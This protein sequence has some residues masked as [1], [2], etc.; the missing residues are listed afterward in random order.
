MSNIVLIRID[1]RLI[2]GQVM[3]GWAKVTLANRIIIIDDQVSKEPFM[4]SV[5]EMAAPPGMAVDVYS[6]EQAEAELMKD[7]PAGERTIVLV[8]SPLT[9]KTFVEKGELAREII[10]GGIGMAPGRKT[11]HR[12]IS[13]SKDEVEAFKEFVSKGIKV[14][15]QVVPDDRKVDI[16]GFLQKM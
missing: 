9:L 6:V 8:K 12:N 5:L 4:K 1:D 10:V 3:T 16:E 15:I 11:L 14:F 2:H 7:S 13:A